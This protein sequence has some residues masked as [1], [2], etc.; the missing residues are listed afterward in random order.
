[1]RLRSPAFAFLLQNPFSLSTLFV[2]IPSVLATGSFYLGGTSLLDPI[3]L[4][5]IVFSVLP[6]YP[7]EI[8][9]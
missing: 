7:I 8:M 9:C 2:L 5:C 3:I 4:V 6:S 1:M